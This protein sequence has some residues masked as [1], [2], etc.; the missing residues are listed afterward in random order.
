MDKSI[1]TELTYTETSSE[2]KLSKSYDIYDN[3]KT[4]I[5]TAEGFA[6]ERGDFLSVIKI[7]HKKSQNKG[8]GFHA[9][10]KIYQELNRI[11]NIKSI[12]G[13]WHS[14]GEF[15]DFENGMSTNL[16]CF[17]EALKLGLTEEAAAFETPTGKWARKLGHN[18]CQIILISTSEVTV[19][20][21]KAS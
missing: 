13:S 4:I 11:T 17:K 10:N 5:G 16:K 20:F 18:I 7:F 1:N 14:G 9:F 2:N 8:I 12:T 15:N 6:N 3:K 19:K 21:I